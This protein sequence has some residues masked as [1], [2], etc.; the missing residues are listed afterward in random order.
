MG[1]MDAQWLNILVGQYFVLAIFL[2][3]TLAKDETDKTGLET[4][5]LHL[6]ILRLWLWFLITMSICNSSFRFSL[7]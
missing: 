3:N 7:Q 5:L 6:L 1:C 2:A 4:Q